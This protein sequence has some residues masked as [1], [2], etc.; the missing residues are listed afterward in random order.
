MNTE[1]I[2]EKHCTRFET[3]DGLL[4]EATMYKRDFAMAIPDILSSQ[5]ET[6]EPTREDGDYI[7]EEIFFRYRLKESEV[8]QYEILLFS[9][10][11][12]WTWDNP[13]L[14]ETQWMR[15]PQ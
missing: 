5:W 13:D 12:N 2:W 6:R 3:G 4:A 15:I 10:Y 7:T 14:Y 8:W 1:Q 11:K 9:K